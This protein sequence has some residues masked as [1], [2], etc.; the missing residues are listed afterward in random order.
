MERGTSRCC[1]AKLLLLAWRCNPKSRKY[2]K[3]MIG[4]KINGPIFIIYYLHFSVKPM[5]VPEDQF[6]R[7]LD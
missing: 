2:Y 3:R 7:L 1:S 5:V 4:P 6:N